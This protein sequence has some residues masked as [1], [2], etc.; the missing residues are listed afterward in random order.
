MQEV[1][2]RQISCLVLLTTV[3]TDLKMI[4]NNNNFIRTNT[5]Y[6]YRYLYFQLLSVPKNLSKDEE[7][8]AFRNPLKPLHQITWTNMEWKNHT[9]NN[10]NRAF[11]QDK[12]LTIQHVVNK[13]PQWWTYTKTHKYTTRYCSSTRY[14]IKKASFET[15]CSQVI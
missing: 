13:S 4:L 8:Q 2:K 7:N 1:Q 3:N 10:H 5:F 14:D 12:I 6:R 9:K 11:W 15:T